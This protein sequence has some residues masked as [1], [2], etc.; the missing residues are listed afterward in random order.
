[1]NDQVRATTCSEPPDFKMK[2]FVFCLKLTGTSGDIFNGNKKKI[3][4]REGSVI[5][6]ETCTRDVLVNISAKHAVGPTMISFDTNILGKSRRFVISINGSFQDASSFYNA[7]Y[8]QYVKGHFT[9]PVLRRGS[10]SMI[11]HHIVLCVTPNL[12][13]G[14]GIRSFK[15]PSPFAPPQCFSFIEQLSIHTVNYWVRVFHPTN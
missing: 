2:E 6:S 12:L 11:Y 9:A 7:T 1:M 14:F 8:V 3:R 4:F 5:E 15:R 10:C 13:A